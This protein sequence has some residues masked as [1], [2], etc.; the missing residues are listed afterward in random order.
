MLYLNFNLLDEPLAIQN[1]TIL[2]LEDSKAFSKLIEDLYTYEE[3]SEARL[4]DDELVALKV[5][6]VQ[7]ISDMLAYDLNS[8]A[9]KKRLVADLMVQF[10]ANYPN[11]LRL[12]TMLVKLTELIRD[13]LLDHEMH[14]QLQDLVFEKFLNSL[15]IKFQSKDDSI[16]EKLLS[17]VQLSAYLHK[18]KLL[19]LVNALAYLNADEINEFKAY[20]ALNKVNVL[21]VEKHKIEHQ[22]QFCLDKDFYFYLVEQSGENNLFIPEI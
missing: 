16:F 13:E 10:N 7:I 20:V 3:D 14:L 22:K 9:L 19:I 4:F 1:L 11:K 15:D 21:C 5:S 8:L 18:C 6:E 17:I 12:E 2:V